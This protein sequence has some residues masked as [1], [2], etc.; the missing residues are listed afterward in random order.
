MSTK[1]CLT[2]TEGKEDAANRTHLV[3]GSSKLLQGQH[4]Q[5]VALIVQEW[6]CST[7]K[8]TRSMRF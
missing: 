5:Q 2:S 4:R 7:G 8:E 3:A 6:V 1:A